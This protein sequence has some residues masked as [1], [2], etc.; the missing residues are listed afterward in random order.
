M[1]KRAGIMG[2]IK[3]IERGEAPLRNNI[4]SPLKKESLREAKPLLHNTFPLV[5]EGDRGD[6]VT[7]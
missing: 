7:E 2:F 5:R 1:I 4:P 3:G 6:R